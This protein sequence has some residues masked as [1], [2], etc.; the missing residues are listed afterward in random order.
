MEK[1]FPE[2]DSIDVRAAKIQTLHIRYVDNI[3][4][5]EHVILNY[6]TIEDMV[7]QMQNLL[8]AY[9]KMFYLMNRKNLQ[10][11]MSLLLLQ[12]LVKEL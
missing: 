1:I 11:F 9:K 7:K 6:T 8:I 4:L 12:V 10:L 5:F 3:D 2:A